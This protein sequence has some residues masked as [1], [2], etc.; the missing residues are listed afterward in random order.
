MLNS[1]SL[2]S[3]IE[4]I[5]ASRLSKAQ[6]LDNISVSHAVTTRL[7]QLDKMSVQLAVASQLAKMVENTKSGVT[8]LLV[9]AF[10]RQAERL[11]AES[12]PLDELPRSTAAAYLGYVRDL[13][14]RSGAGAR[15][16]KLMKTTLRVASLCINNEYRPCP[17]EY[18]TVVK[19]LA[20]DGIVE[21]DIT[22]LRGLG[23]LSLLD[24]DVPVRIRFELD[25]IAEYCAI[26]YWREKSSVDEWQSIRDKAQKL[27]PASAE[28][29]RAIED[30]ENYIAARDN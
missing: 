25:P 28:F 4:S 26:E 2:V 7:A 13:T 20:Q 3:L 5:L 1:E 6:A 15:P 21:D 18:E 9:E 8:P 24:S 27:L 16:F 12:R 23:L 14:N 10:V 17:A 22:A 19:T 29:I 30:I 11:I